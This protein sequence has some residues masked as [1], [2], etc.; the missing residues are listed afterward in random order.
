L[1]AGT[2]ARPPPSVTVN[3]AR[4]SFSFALS[5]RK[6]VSADMVSPTSISENWSPAFMP[7]IRLPISAFCCSNS[8][9]PDGVSRCMLMD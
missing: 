9:F 7:S 4:A 8:V 2:S 1:S 3:F 6:P 5:R